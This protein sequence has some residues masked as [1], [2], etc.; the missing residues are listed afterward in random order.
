MRTQVAI[1]GGGP[2]GSVL[3]LLLQRAG[4]DCVVLERR[5]RSYVLARIRAGVLEHGTTEVLRD[6]GLGQ[7]MQAGADQHDGVYLAFGG[8]RLHIDCRR[9]VGKPVT[10]WGQ[11]EVQAELYGAMEDRGVRMLHDADEVALHDV[12][13]ERPWITFT[14]NGTQERLDCDWIA[15]CD[16]SH[17]TSSRAIPRDLRR[18]FERVY[19]FGWLGILS[20]TPPVSDQLIY[21]NHDR[22][23]ALCSMRS[24][25]L[26]RYYVQCPVDARLE[27][28]PDDRFWDELSARLPADVAAELVTGPS[29]DKSIAPLSSFVAEP[30]RH[31]RLLLVGDAAHIVPPTGAKG[32]N[33]AIGDAVYLARALVQHYGDGSDAGLEAYSSTALRRVW[34]AV[35]FSWWMTTLLHRFPQTDDAFDRKIQIAELEYLA[36]SES[37]RRTLAENYVGLPL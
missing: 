28:W 13:G 33:L 26:S 30:M 23:F 15:G 5:S 36:R 12:A 11:T 2:A 9:L 21:A 17:G 25:Q 14:R 24:D 22:G 8:D 1:V 7:R 27:D 37:A 6:L 10:V 18:T 31:G 19:P 3:S 20:K 32:L 4:I 34:Q 35:R 16:G 29:I